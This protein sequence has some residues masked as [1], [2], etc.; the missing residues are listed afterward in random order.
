M[1][2]DERDANQAVAKITYGNQVAYI[3]KA[4]LTTSFNSYAP[5][6]VQYYGMSYQQA[7]DYIVKSLAQRELLVLYAKAKIAELENL[8][9]PE[10]LELKQFVSNL[11]YIDAIESISDYPD[12]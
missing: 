4:Q 7:A 6:Y 3:T 8:G 1:K 10:N 2:N 11:E 12:D 9:A 5:S